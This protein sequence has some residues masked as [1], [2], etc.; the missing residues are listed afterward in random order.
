[1]SPA[2]E[3][4]DYVITIKPR[5]FR[6]GFIYV[7]DHIDLGRIIK[8]LSSVQDGDLVVSGDNPSSTPDAL[9]APITS[10][11]VL[12]Q[13]KWVVG[14]SAGGDGGSGSGFPGQAGSAC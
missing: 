3:D 10:D 13:V 11:R 2:L 7:I 8:R 9:I 4:G 6:P 5:S 12:G 1:M 14:K